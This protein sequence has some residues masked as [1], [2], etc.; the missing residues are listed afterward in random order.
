MSGFLV[1]MKGVSKD[2]DGVSA[3]DNVDFNVEHG[4]IHGL[5]GANG[6]GKST[7]M[8]ILAGAYEKY[9]GEITINDEK[10]VIKNPLEAKNYGVHCVYQEVDTALIPNLTVKE[11]IMLDSLV[12]DKKK[13]RL[14][15]KDIKRKAS[16]VLDKLKFYINPDDK[17][18]NLSLAQKQLVLIARA[19]TQKVKVLILDEPTA[20]LSNGETE[21]LF[22][23]LK[24]LKN[25]GVG[26]IFISHRLNELIQIT[27]SITV[28]RDGQVV[29]TLVTKESDVNEIINMML[30][31]SNA[32]EFRI[33]HRE[34]K[35]EIFRVENLYWEDK[36]NDVSLRVNKGEIVGIAGLVGAGKTELSKVIFGYLKKDKGKLFKNNKEIEVLSTSKAVKEGIALIP[37]ERRKEGILVEENIKKNVTLSN[38][39]KFCKGSFFIDDRQESTTS[40]DII[41]ALKIK[42][43]DE[44]QK[45]QFLSGGN[46]QKVSIGKW[47]VND[48]DIYIFDEVTKGVDVGAKQEIYGIISELASKGKAIIYISCEPSEILSLTDRFYVMYDGRIVKEIIS[49]NSSEDEILYYSV[50]GE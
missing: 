20:P 47:L 31:K 6:A 43:N 18:E 41:E 33:K 29:D 8:K 32:E 22:D 4:M 13:S 2:F 42:C 46:Q 21:K 28:M 23:I 48:S 36:L 27:D 44:N 34:I 5:I 16:D 14:D 35:E 38:L 19:L 39:K 3:L 24:E 40:R 26:I 12:K 17:I 49:K 50:G 11:N 25:Q 7:L 37:E 15:W 9:Q 1:E 45:V 30:G 10:A